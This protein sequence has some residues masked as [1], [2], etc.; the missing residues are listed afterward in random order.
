M[1]AIG[2]ERSNQKKK[3]VRLKLKALNIAKIFKYDRAIRNSFEKNF[4]TK[5]SDDHDEVFKR[6]TKEIRNLG[7]RK[8]KTLKGKFSD[9]HV[10]RKHFKE[11]NIFINLFFRKK[12]GIKY[13]QI[14]LMIT[15]K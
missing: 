11:G 8:L 3:L 10:F 4:R 13:T 6:I 9:V 1:K 5:R 12:W 2:N 14:F 7:F 15:W